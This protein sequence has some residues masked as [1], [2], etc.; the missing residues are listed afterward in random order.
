MEIRDRIK[1]LRKV[2]ASELLPN[3]KNWRKHPDAQANALR[4]T[5]S[6]IGYADALIAY[7]TPNG[8]MLIDGHLR[9]E[10]SGAEMVPVL[11]LDVNE[12][13][14]DILL[15]T[16]DPIGAMATTDKE[17]VGELL[18]S[19][20]T[21]NEAVFDILNGLMGISDDVYLDNGEADESLRYQVIVECSA[22]DHQKAVLIKLN[23]EGYKCR[24][25]IS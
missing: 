25:L 22:E 12:A 6:E 4:G 10:T 5:L 11:V 8:L 15:A 14:A 3:P 20:E 17:K 21:N 9:A 2:K 1:E 7:E 19:I 16:F 18:D 13:E 24:L 23:S